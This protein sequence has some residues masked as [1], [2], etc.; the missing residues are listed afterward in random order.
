MPVYRITFIS[1]IQFRPHSKK[2]PYTQF[3][4]NLPSQIKQHRF[5]KFSRI[6]CTFLLNRVQFILQCIFMEKESFA[7][8]SE[9]HFF[10]KINFQ[11]FLFLFV[12][13]TDCLGSKFFLIFWCDRRKNQLKCQIIENNVVFCGKCKTV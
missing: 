7:C 2:N 10:G 4:L 11:K 8:G 13:C 1:T 9:R 3:L 6:Q 5:L 12:E